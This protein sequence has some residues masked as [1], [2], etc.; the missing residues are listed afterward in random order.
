MRRKYQGFISHDVSLVYLGIEDY[1]LACLFLPLAAWT[2]GL[3]RKLQLS[4]TNAKSGINYREKTT[5]KQKSKPKHENINYS[6]IQ[7][8]L[9][10]TGLGVAA[11]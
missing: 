2:V 11:S 3:K 6:G 4:F 8:N 7:L 5:P 9:I 1:L 10:Y